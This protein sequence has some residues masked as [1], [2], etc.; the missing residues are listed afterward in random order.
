L[1]ILRNLRSPRRNWARQLRVALGV[2]LTI[3]ELV[4]APRW[5]LDRTMA[6]AGRVRGDTLGPWGDNLRTRFGADALARVHARLPTPVAPVLSDRDRVPVYA[7]LL[8][9]E[10]IVDEFL[11]GDMLAL[12]PLIVADTR[13]GIGAIKLTTMRV[14]GIGNVLRLGPR[15][16]REIHE[17]GDHDVTVTSGRAE[18]RF[19]NNPLFAHPTWRVLQVFA[20]RVL[21]EL[22]NARGTIVGDAPGEDAFTAIATWR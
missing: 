1:P 10:A 7:Q 18:M 13:A 11:G 21:F 2:A 22:V 19:A 14:M 8:V 9:T 4:T 17:R 12:L 15:T 3:D 20:T 16:F 6:L 5:P